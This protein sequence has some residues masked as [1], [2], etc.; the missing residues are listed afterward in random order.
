[1]AYRDSG[2]GGFGFGFGF[3][4]TPWV[5]RLLIAN[6]AVFVLMWLLRQLAG[7]MIWPWL[8]F[9]P[10]AVLTQPWGLITYMFVHGSF[11][12]LFINMLVLFFFGPPL[13]STWG[14]R[15]FIK[16]YLIAGLGGAA[17]SFVFAFD[18]SIIGASAAVYGIMLAFAM[19]W[20]D[21]PIYIWGIF[22]IKAKWLVTIFFG[23]S[24][25]YAV[26]GSGGNTAHFAHLGGV[27]SGFLY[28][29]MSDRVAMHS[30]GTL[31]RMKKR[32]SRFSKPRLTILPKDQ[33]E[34]GGSRRR[35]PRR[36]RDEE[37][38]LDEVDRLL[39]KISTQG[40]SSLTDKEKRLLDDM[41]RK[42]R[43]D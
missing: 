11:W 26:T 20:P 42:Y 17:L 12:H 9:V 15:E 25:I 37:R 28:L 38:M 24:F 14:S 7:V 13:E 21:A 41:S 27:L 3:G 6:A 40:L 18:A 36:P 35:P 22:P 5:K 32:V 31:K 39:D 16:Y 8:A 29:K 10:G 33:E 1:M 4:M 2:S 23:I 43:R 19:N 34:D 30:S